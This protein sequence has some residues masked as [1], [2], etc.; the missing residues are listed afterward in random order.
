MRV[1]SRLI[2]FF[3]LLFCFFGSFS[4]NQELSDDVVVGLYKVEAGE[5]LYRISRNFFL[6]EKDIMEVNVGLTAESLCQQLDFPL[7]DYIMLEAGRYE[8]VC[9]TCIKML[10]QFYNISMRNL[11]I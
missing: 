9:C 11:P 6:T 10:C 7:D 3:V 1:F 4:Q 2:C 5:T 8:E